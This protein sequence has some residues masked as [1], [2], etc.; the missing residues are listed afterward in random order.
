MQ[1]IIT[2]WLNL[3]MLILVTACNGDTV[4][5]GNDIELTQQQVRNGQMVY[6]DQCARCHDP[7]MVGPQ[8]QASTLAVYGTAQGLFEYTRQ[9]MPQDAPGTLSEQ[10]Y[11]DVTA[12]MM[13]ETGLLPGDTG[14]GPANAP[15]IEFN[16]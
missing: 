4:G 7:G 16:P 12:H 3:V 6:N 5:S 8:L 2:G 1:K 9:T 15:E 11:W 10:E 14:L 13:Q